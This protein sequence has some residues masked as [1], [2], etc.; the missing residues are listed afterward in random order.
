MSLSLIL[1]LI[2]CLVVGLVLLAFMRTRGMAREAERLVPQAGQ[3]QP[4][5]GGSVH[6]VDLGPK[7][8]PPLV[9]IHGLSGQLQ[10]FTYALSDLL[11]GEFR[12]IA[13]DRPGCGYSERSDAALAAPGEQGR[14]IGEALDALGVSDPVLVGHSLGGAVALAMAMDRPDKTRALALLCPATQPQNE[15]PEVFRGLMVRTAWLRQAI[16]ATIAVP[17]AAATKDKVLAMVFHP[18]PAPGDFMIRAGAALGLRPSGFT[19]ASEDAVSLLETGAAQAARY[20]AELR[21]PGG[22]LFGAADAILSPAAHGHTMAAHGL[23]CETLDGRGH[24]IPMTAPEDCADFIRRMTA[25][26]QAAESVG[27]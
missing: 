16:G 22:V 26:P 3:V 12:V 17:M 7:D 10:H 21:V 5:R 18:E 15:V 14:M 27:K 6:F 1:W 13:V 11:A 9:M 2:L 4:V 8:A 23:V 20:A 19:T 24:M 25:A